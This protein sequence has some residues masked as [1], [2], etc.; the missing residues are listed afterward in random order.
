MISWLDE[1]H[2][3]DKA[4][5][6]ELRQR[7]DAK[8]IEIVD[9]TQRLQELEARLTSTQS[10]FSLFNTLE[11]S[12][13]NVREEITLMVR[14]VEEDLQR[15]RRE[16][17]H[18]RAEGHEQLGRAVGD[19]QRSLESIPPL[20]ERIGALRTEDSRL[21]DGI[22]NL[23]V[24][25][26]AVERE[27]AKVTE[28]IGF[29]EGQRGSHTAG[30][31]KVQEASDVLRRRLD[32]LENRQRLIDELAHK[33]EQRVGTFLP[34]RDEIVNRQKEFNEEIRLRVA[35]MAR[36]KRDWEETLQQFDGE[37]VKQRNLLDTFARRL[38]ADREVVKQLDDF[39]R[40]VNLE[41]QQVAEL[42]RLSAERQQDALDE[43]LKADESRWTKFQ[44][45]YDAE[46]Q[47]NREN[48]V[49]LTTRL[50]TLEEKNP[51]Y[52]VHLKN[53]RILLDESN[54]AMRERLA[55][56]WVLQEESAVFHLDASRR[57]YDRMAGLLD[58]LEERSKR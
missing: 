44:R 52:D 11:Q 57:W 10:R 16:Q 25:L 56:I 46:R 58:E 54:Q 33:N 21:N 15:A 36:D 49:A 2:R 7:L 19:L 37:F 22:A 13:Q 24:R 55:E 1:E 34:M 23:Q 35:A 39:K 29:V 12:I 9:L 32:M 42:Q 41:Q 17:D 4:I 26:V 30:I 50:S 38:D 18:K 43:W 40:V 27:S 31:R 45:Q 8:E 6:G 20:Q 5:I 47:I 51:E 48:H 28:R 3:K 14:N 53:I